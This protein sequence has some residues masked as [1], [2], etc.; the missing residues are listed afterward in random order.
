MDFL[1]EFAKS[2]RQKR[3]EREANIISGLQFAPGAA[4]GSTTARVF[5]PPRHEQLAKYEKKFNK[6]YNS[7]KDTAERAKFLKK[8]GKNHKAKFIKGMNRRRMAL[9]IAA[10]IGGGLLASDIPKRFA[11]YMKNK[12]RSKK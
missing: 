11:N 9:H 7:I 8:A 10:T 2:Q 12:K 6:K 5:L 1:A 3:R 4:L